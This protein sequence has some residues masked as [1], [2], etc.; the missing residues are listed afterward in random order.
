MRSGCC[1]KY[2]DRICRRSTTTSRAPRRSRSRASSRRCASP[3]A[4]SR[5]QTIALPGRGRSGDRHR[6][7]GRRG[8]GRRRAATRRRRGG[9]AGSSIRGP[10]RQAARRP[11]RAQAA[12][13]ARACAGRR[14]ARRGERAAADGD[15]RRRRRR[16][17]VHRGRRDARWR[18]INERPIVFALSN[19]TSKSEC[20]ARAG[21]PLVG[22]P[23]AVRLRLPFDPV[24]H[25][26]A[27]TFVPRQGNNSYIFPGVGL[28][29]DR[30]RAPAASPTRCSWRRRARSPSRS[31]RPTCGRAASIRRFRSY[32]R[33]VG[34]YR[35]G[36][37]QGRLRAGISRAHRSRPT[38]S[39]S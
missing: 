25:R 33:R 31:P 9:A 24:T 18:R 28:G 19:P 8:D 35:G 34:A 29:V 15:H 21:L 22:R 26:T 6:R 23:R 7:S 36:G 16:R 37:R 20:T 12:V 38:F 39:R 4:S 10:R 32:S 2:R 27:R 1:A 3:A 30:R 17:R 13:R 14:P 5:E 11:R